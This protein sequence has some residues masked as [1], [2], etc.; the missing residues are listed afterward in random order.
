MSSKLVSQKPVILHSSFFIF[1]F[2]LFTFHFS[3][4][5]RIWR[6]SAAL[7]AIFHYAPTLAKA[8]L[9]F[10][11]RRRFHLG[12]RRGAPLRKQRPFSIRPNSNTFTWPTPYSIIA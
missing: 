11:V 7:P 12:S 5:T 6:Q 9:H 4:F 2:S 8:S 1:H 10:P 3:L